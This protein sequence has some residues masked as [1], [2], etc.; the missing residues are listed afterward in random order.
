MLFQWSGRDWLVHSPAKLNLYLEILDRRQDGYHELE[1]CMV[2]V[3]LCDTLRFRSHPDRLTLQ[4]IGG[5]GVPGDETNLVIQ[6][7]AALQKTTG[8][9]GGAT[10]L[11]RKRVP[12]GAGL[13][14]G[15]ANAAAALLVLN[16]LWKLGLSHGELAGIAA[17]LGSDLNF[18]LES[19]PAAVCRGR[20]EQVQPV[21]LPRVC[22]FVIAW[23]H[24]QLSTGD[25]FARCQV[26]HRAITDFDARLA[27]GQ[28]R[29]HNRLQSAA[30]RVRPELAHLA[31]EFSAITSQHQMTG[32]GSAW[33]GLMPHRRA[34]RRAARWLAGRQC[35]RDVRVAASS[36]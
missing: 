32:S 20:G 12:A 26:S 14:G 9:A 24:F 10:I 31:T 35:V 7:A 22:H 29:L 8:F 4:V 21:R 17:G 1:T 18:F 25:V 23:P 27:N 13:G 30:L 19:V 16:R 6:A 5:S 15:S 36:Y 3:N 28:I 33:F 34:A 2:S 11:L